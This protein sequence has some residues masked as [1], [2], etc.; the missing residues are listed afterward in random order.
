MWSFHFHQ[1]PLLDNAITDVILPC[2]ER[3]FSACDADD[4][5]QKSRKFRGEA[6]VK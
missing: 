1:R 6:N 3:V 4:W 2:H 5:R